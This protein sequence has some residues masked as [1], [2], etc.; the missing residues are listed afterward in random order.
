MLVVE[1]PSLQ[2]V[3]QMF[4]EVVVSRRGIRWI[5]QMRQNFIAQVTQLLTCWL[6]QREVRSC[7][8]KELGSSSWPTPPVGT[9]VFGAS[10]QSAER[11]SQMYWFRRD[12]ESCSGLADYQGPWPFFG[13]SLAL[14]SALELP[15]GS[16]TELVI[17]SSCIKST[18][19]LIKKCLLLLHSKTTHQNCNSSDLQSAHEAPT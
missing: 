8:G 5:W 11:T 4:E 12:S 1:A 15:L 17:A 10:H 13:T 19:H 7:R 18:F 9:A 16:P 2:K 6:Y 14:G 3:V